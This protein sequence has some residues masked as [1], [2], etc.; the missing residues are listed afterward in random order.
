MIN[1]LQAAIGAFLLHNVITLLGPSI[2]LKDLSSYV[3]LHLSSAGVLPKEKVSLHYF[4]SRGRMEPIRVALSDVG[5]DFVDASFHETQWDSELKAKWDSDGT[6]A[7]GQ[8]PL[9]QIDSYNLVQ[10]HAILRYFGRKYGFY[11]EHLYTVNEL[12]IIDMVSDGTA[13]L[14]AKIKGIQYDSSLTEEQRAIKYEQYFTQVAPAWFQRFERLL[15]NSSSAYFVSNKNPT[16]CDYLFLDLVDIHELL[17]QRWT[18]EILKTTP[19]IN[20]FLRTIRE[21]PNI[22][23]YLGSPSR[24]GH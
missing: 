19:K 4:D 18:T 24:R 16:I 13:D 5:V 6:I 20:N 10:S 22:K 21:R 14:R 23:A 1:I 8:V 9:V 3:N 17:G 2:G 7:F 12:G 11:N 15:K